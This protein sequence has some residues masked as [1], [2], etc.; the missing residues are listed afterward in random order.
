MRYDY[1]ML[2]T[3]VYSAS[4]EAGERWSL[5]DVAGKPIRAWDSRGHTFRIEYD[6]LRRPLRDFVIGGDARTPTRAC[7]ATKCCLR[8]SSTARARQTT[9]RSTCARGYSSCTTAPA[10][11]PAKRYDFKGN[12][13]R[14]SRQLTRDYRARPIGRAM[15]RWKKK[16]TP[17]APPTT[18]S[19]G[20]QRPRQ[21]TAASSV[22]AFNEANL[23]ERVDANLRG[24]SLN[25]KP[26]WQPFVTHIAYDARGQRERIDYA[27]GARTQ[28]TYD[29]LTF[30]LVRLLTE[31]NT[32]VF[33]DDCPS[34]P[35]AGWPGCAA[36]NLTYTYDPVGN[37]TH[38]QDDAQQTIYFRNRRVEPSADYTY[39]AVYQLIEATGREHLSP[40]S[41]PT[42][43]VPTAPDAFDASHTESG[44]PGRWPGDG[45]L[46]RKLRV[47]RGR[48]HSA[49]ASIGRQVAAGL[50][51]MRMPSPA[52]SRPTRSAIDSLQRT[53]PA[54]NWNA[55]ATTRTAA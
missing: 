6:A 31:R 29:P 42:H 46:S 4:M 23:L 47:R 43:A 16:S 38:I 15:L 40:M 51:P 21:P 11:P 48:Q 25:G 22:P 18:P 19:T 9:S 1:D 54:V 36:Q 28:Y 24:E 35:P 8:R 32:A 27:N 26:V 12:P 10:S 55:T 44:A 34:V 45:A 41:G 2:G 5:E 17:V 20:Q 13:L 37:I 14:G 49:D 7:W 53:L 50:A 52:S 3:Q 39:D 30:R 33:A